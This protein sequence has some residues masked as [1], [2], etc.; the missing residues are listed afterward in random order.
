MA[1]DGH[2]I[3][4]KLTRVAVVVF[5]ICC[6]GQFFF[7]IFY[8]ESNAQAKTVNQIERTQCQCKQLALRCERSIASIHICF[9]SIFPFSL[10]SR[11]SARIFPSL[12]ISDLIFYFLFFCFPLIHKLNL[13]ESTRKCIRNKCD[14][15]PL[16]IGDW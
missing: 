16:T 4:S 7:S 9:A 15:R 8:F 6:F 13:R 1:R 12:S 3:S 10:T 14:S 11:S 2:I 5:A